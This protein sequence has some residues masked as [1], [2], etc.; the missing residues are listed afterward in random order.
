LT[1]IFETI[2]GAF[3]LLEDAT[4]D[5]CAQLDSETRIRKPSGKPTWIQRSRSNHYFD[6]EAMA[7]AAGHLLNVQ[8]I[9][10]SKQAPQT[11]ST[12]K[13][14]PGTEVRTPT[15]KANA[16]KPRSGSILIHSPCAL[17]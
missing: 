14:T 10:E 5:Y 8:R 6:C 3:H 1:S 12:D 9:P 2:T 13:E 7:Y 16:V 15:I 17:R 11:G 4:D